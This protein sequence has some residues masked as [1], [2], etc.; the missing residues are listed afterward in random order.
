LKAAEQFD[1]VH[2]EFTATADKL[3]SKRNKKQHPVLD[4]SPHERRCGQ[5]NERR[6]VASIRPG[7]V[8]YV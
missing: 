5:L 1:D 6:P 7:G 4:D 2:L 3:V 8:P